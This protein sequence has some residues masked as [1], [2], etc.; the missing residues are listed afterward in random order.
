M[1]PRLCACL[2]LATAAIG[3]TG[4]GSS[5]R[6]STKA[7]ASASAISKIHHN[8]VAFF[9]PS[10]PTSAKIAL[11]QNGTQFAPAIDALTKSPFAKEVSAKVDAVRLTSPTTAA[12]TFTVLLAGAPVLKNAAGDA[13]KTGSTWQVADASFC[14]LLKLQGP[15]PP[16]CPKG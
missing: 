16:A 1:R 11:L 14:Q 7:S 6:S 9:N 5:G 13:I 10:T 12:V 15:A 3:V 8:W 4:C 2:A